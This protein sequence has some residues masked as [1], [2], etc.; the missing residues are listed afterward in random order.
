MPGG[1]LSLKPKRA[2]ETCYG[3]QPF[4]FAAAM[5]QGETI[6]TQVVVATVYQGTDP[7]PGLTVNGPAASQNTTQVIQSF[8]AGVPGCV[9]EMSCQVTTSYGQVLNQAAYLAVIPDLV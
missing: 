4:D 1:H 6:L 7:T 5:A 8:Q 2:S 9:Y 3:S